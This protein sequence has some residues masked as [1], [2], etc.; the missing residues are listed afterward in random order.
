MNMQFVLA[1]FKV[2]LFALVHVRNFS[3]SLL[4]R[5]VSVDKLGPEKQIVVSSA[6]KMVE[7]TFEKFGRS[8]MYSKNKTGAIWLPCGIPT[9][10]IL[11]SE[12]ELETLNVCD[13]SLRKLSNQLS[14]MPLIP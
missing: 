9:F 14:A 6:N 1:T 7:A 12:I 8:L 10:K 2:S 3:S 5:E 11:L 13:R 4:Q